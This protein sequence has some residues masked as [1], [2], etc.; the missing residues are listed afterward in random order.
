MKGALGRCLK[1]SKFRG[2]GG[3]GRKL[4]PGALRVLSML[5]HT[6]LLTLRVP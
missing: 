5:F 6:I 1:G 3:L 2:G 4:T